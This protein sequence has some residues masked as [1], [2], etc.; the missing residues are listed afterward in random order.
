MAGG[1]SMRG[2]FYRVADRFIC[3]AIYPY[4]YSISVC[5][6]VAYRRVPNI[7]NPSDIGP[8]ANLPVP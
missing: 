3:L 8:D 6:G 1:V 2:A 7:K 5:P 4:G